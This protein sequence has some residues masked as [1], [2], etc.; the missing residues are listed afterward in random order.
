M[1]AQPLVLAT[2]VLPC[3]LS[4]RLENENP[5]IRMQQDPKLI[6]NLGSSLVTDDR[7]GA[8]QNLAPIPMVQT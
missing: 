4:P 1:I 2:D 3:G 5:V 7:P 8:I 6:A